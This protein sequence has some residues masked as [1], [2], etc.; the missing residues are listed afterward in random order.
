MPYFLLPT[1]LKSVLKYSIK[2]PNHYVQ[3]I[4]K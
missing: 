1:K 2:L 3:T 4:E